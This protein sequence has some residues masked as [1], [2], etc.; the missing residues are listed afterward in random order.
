MP[1]REGAAYGSPRSRG[2]RVAIVERRSISRNESAIVAR[3]E[4]SAIRE[5]AIV[6]MLFPD[7][8]RAPSGLRKSVQHHAFVLQQP[9]LALQSAAVL[10]QRTI[11]ADQAMAGQDD[12][13]RI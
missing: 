6:E 5:I 9:A 2:R 4:R 3:M 11:G 7:F 10:D 8:A 13:E 12:A 1:E